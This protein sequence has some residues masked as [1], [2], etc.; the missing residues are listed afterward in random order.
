MESD[1]RQ[2]KALQNREP[3]AWLAVYHELGGDLFGYAYH[4]LRGDL[5]LTEET[6]QS[7]WLTAIEMS[8]QFD[9]NRGTFRNWLFAIAR[10]RIILHYRLKSNR[11]QETS[12]LELLGALH[13]TDGSSLL[14]P[15]DV[16][17]QLERRDVIR[18]AMLCLPDDRRR[19]LFGKYVD[20][21]TVAELAAS[22]R[23]TEKAVESLLFRAKTQLRALLAHYFE[24]SQKAPR[25]VDESK[26]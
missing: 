14:T 3:E 2:L 20:G 15:P 10:Q 16:M 21:L 11:P 24:T 19:V 26:P 5:P 13:S 17:E 18:A 12:N 25:N 6:T 9:P 8:R 7:T 1:G 4:L 22:N 23:Q